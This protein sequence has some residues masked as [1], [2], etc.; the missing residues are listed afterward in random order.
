MNGPIA[1]LVAITYH[2]NAFLSGLA[3]P[4][5]FPGNSTCQFCDYVHFLAFHKTLLGKRKAKIIAENPN[6]WFMFLKQNKASGIRL[7]RVQQNDPN[8]PDRITA[9]FVGGGG[10]WFMEILFKH[11]PSELWMAKWDVWDQ[12][13]P[14]QRIWRVDYFY[15]Q[16]VPQKDTKYRDLE[17]VWSE[18][19]QSLIEIHDFSRSYTEGGFTECFENAL[20]AIDEPE[21]D[22]GYHKDL[23]LKDQ[24]SPK[25]ISILKAAMS[26]WV[27]GGMGSWNDMSFD[28][29]AQKIYERV[30]QKHFNLL[31]EAI[32]C[33]AS[34]SYPH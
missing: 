6:A 1:Q 12:N 34:S 23:F 27:Y 32:E 22:I 24:L 11:K 2:G 9:G 7:L 18:F 28:V 26:S 15:I 17:Q 31:N 25:A 8:L 19:K 30:S 13:A 33:A 3:I 16:K 20:I 29:E 10:D 4:V 21:A 5:F 14:E